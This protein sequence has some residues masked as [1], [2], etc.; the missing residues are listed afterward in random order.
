MFTYYFPTKW[1]AFGKIRGK[2][3]MAP[4]S[5]HTVYVL[6]LDRAQVRLLVSEGIQPVNKPRLLILKGFVPEQVKEVN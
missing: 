3:I 1:S 4:F 5:G 6:W 2:N